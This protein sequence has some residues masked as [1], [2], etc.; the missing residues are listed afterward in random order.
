M[1]DKFN[2]HIA[3]TVTLV[4]LHDLLYMYIYGCK[5][6]ASMK[7]LFQ[8]DKY[9]FKYCHIATTLTHISKNR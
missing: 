7:L 4:A 8:K 3:F 1:I 5:V 2:I 6:A 9:D